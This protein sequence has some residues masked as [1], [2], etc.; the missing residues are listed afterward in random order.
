VLKTASQGE[1]H[2]VEAY[3]KALK[4]DIPSDTRTVAQ[5]QLTEIQAARTE[6]Q[7]LLQTTTG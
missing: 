5:R 2:A 7:R 3:E 6:L 4:E 1:E